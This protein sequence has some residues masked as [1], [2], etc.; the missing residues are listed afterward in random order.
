VSQFYSYEGKR[1]VVTGGASGVGAALVALLDTLGTPEVTVLDV[2]EPTNLAP[3]QRWVPTDLSDPAAIAASIDSIESLDTLFNNA[4]VA[5]T[6]PPRTVFA[7]NVL[8]PRYLATELGNRMRPGGAV[9]NTASTAGNRWATHLEAIDEVLAVGD[10]DKALEW[11]DSRH[12]D[13]GVDTYSFSKECL[14]VMTLRSAIEYGQR[15]LRITSVC[16]SPIDTPLLPDFRA[17]YSDKL[18]DWSIGTSGGLSTAAEVAQVLA[19][20]GM[21]AA[22]RVSGVNLHIDGGSTAGLLMGDI[23]VSSILG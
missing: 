1:V 3:N 17:T 15:G 12:A 16:P 8:A 9:V 20:L 21:D 4:A 7:V 6:A 13:L 10:W 5:G 22:S 11:F 23:S 18:I 2:A 14:Q 19:F